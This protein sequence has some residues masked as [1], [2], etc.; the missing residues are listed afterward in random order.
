MASDV[1]ISVNGVSKTF[2]LPH[3][4]YTSIKSA[5]IHFY[6]RRR[7]YEQQQVLQNVSL[8]IKKGEFF[9]IVGRNGSGK[10]T[11]LKLLAGIYTPNKGHIQINGKLTPFIELGVGFNPELSGRENVFLNGA[12]LGFN[13]KEME[14]MYDDIVEFAELERFMD[15]KLKNYSSGMQVRLAFSI[16]IRAQSDI[17][18]IDEVLAVGDVNF[19]KKCFDYFYKL[20]KN[21]QTVI[22]VTH[23]MSAVRDFCDR[24]ALIHDGKIKAIG[25]ASKIAQ[26]YSLLNLRHDSQVTPVSSRAWGTGEL[27]I[28]ECKPLY[29]D[30]KQ[31]MYKP[32]ENIHIDLTVN[33]REHIENAIIGITVKDLAGREIFVTNTKAISKTTGSFQPGSVL[34]IGFEFQNA[35][36]DG[37]YTVTPAIANESITEFYSVIEEACT[38]EVS[39][40]TFPTGIVQVLPKIQI[41]ELKTQRRGK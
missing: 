22:L 34:R 15:Q 6:N 21:K 8:E 7:G 19:Q 31:K 41:Q 5:F 10:S 27:E 28:V 33:V 29:K 18:L 1:A 35:F 13:R 14:A 32:N 20:K 25:E 24:A 36:N 12:L 17:L 4:K 39:G 40:W 30:S 23:D 9:G 26:E 2:K 37:T 16:A 11:L 3:E 38:F